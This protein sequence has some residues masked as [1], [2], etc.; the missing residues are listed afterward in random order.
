MRFW[1]RSRPAENRD[2]AIALRSGA[3]CGAG[4]R[5]GRI[6]LRDEEGLIGEP[7]NPEIVHDAKPVA[8]LNG[9]ACCYHMRGLMNRQSKRLAAPAG[10]QRAS[11]AQRKPTWLLPV[12]G[13]VPRRAEGR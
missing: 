6:L 10:N 5:V 8:V 4:N 1:R 9:K 12:S 11:I 13:G 3:Y 7:Q 2:K